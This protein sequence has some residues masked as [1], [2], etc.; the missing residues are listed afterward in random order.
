MISA[1]FMLLRSPSGTVLLLRRAKG[2][3]HAGTWDIPGGKIKTG[4]SPEEAA[5]REVKEETGFLTG[6][7]GRFHCRR[8]KN[9]VDATTFLFD[10]D[11]EFVPKLN[12]EHDAW[13][14]MDPFEA[15]EASDA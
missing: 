14:W 13:R 6:H 10:C 5:I 12:K 1:A 2:E 3:D 15:L 4:E 9:S 11:S 7:S 8:V